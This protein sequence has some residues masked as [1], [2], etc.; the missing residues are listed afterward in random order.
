MRLAAFLLICVAAF[1]C[2]PIVDNSITYVETAPV[3]SVLIPY[4]AVFEEAYGERVLFS[5]LTLANISSGGTLGQCEMISNVIEIDAQFFWGA[6]EWER[7]VVILHELGHC[8]LKRPHMNELDGA[9]SK[10]LMHWTPLANLTE[11]HYLM[12]RNEYI[13]ELFGRVE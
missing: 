8:V 13:Q 11:Y 1:R 2:G 12:H 10:S 4:L 5:K 6:A 9:R 7:E 3:D